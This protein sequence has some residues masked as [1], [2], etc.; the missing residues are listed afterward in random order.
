MATAFKTAQTLSR[1]DLDIF[2]TN[3]AGN[4]SNCYSQTYGI[5][6]VDPVTKAE[7]L[8][9]SATRAPVN[10]AVGEYYAA[11]MVPASAVPG[12]YR[13]RWTFKET[14]V[15]PEQQVVQE[16]AVV[17]DAVQTTATTMSGAQALL[18]RKLR[19]MLGDND[20]DRTYR[21]QPPKGEGS[22]GCNDS[23]FGE[24]WTDE[25]LLEFLKMALDQW[26]AMP[27]A[28]EEL[29]DLDAMSQRKP[30]WKAPILW[31]AVGTAAMMLAFRWTSEEFDY[32]IGGISLSIDKSSKYQSLKE[33]AEQQFTALA[34]AKSRTVFY[35]RGLRQQRFSP[36]VR[37]A[38]GPNLGS[39]VLSPRSFL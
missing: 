36:G 32:N 10:P 18:V 34:E 17:S 5:Y 33:N 25:E 24:I 11:L 39:S 29:C 2:I 1:G 12:D 15:T 22:I 38:F 35:L 13:I 23:V 30:S 4:P 8:I 6:Y 31:G 37:S 7:V 28:T 27:P 21:F 9:G 14:S 26:N 3:S 19:F 16:F 20:P